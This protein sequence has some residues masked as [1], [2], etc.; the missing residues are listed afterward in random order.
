MTERPQNW[1]FLGDSLTEGVGSG[2][3]SY[4]TELAAQLRAADEELVV[5]DMRL[6]KVDPEGFNRFIRCNI[7]G[8]LSGDLRPARRRLW[9]WNLACEGRTIETDAEWLPLLDALRPCRVIVFRGSLESI[10]RPAMLGD[11]SWPWWVPQS[12]RSYAAMDPRCYFST[13][14]WRRVKQGAID[15]LKQTVRLSLLQRRTGVTL[16]DLDAL[17]AHYRTLLVH[18]RALDARV[19]MLGLLTTDGALFPGSPERFALVNVRLRE[20]AIA[21]GAEFFDWRT[22]F[23]QSPGRPG[24]LYRD[25]FHPN[26]DGARALATI[27]REHLSESSR[28]G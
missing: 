5:Q 7:A 17:I 25:G 14:W 21:Q 20:L 23:E 6:R 28:S 13:T 3:I 15:T 10:V 12:W 18:L 27:L 11:D 8:Y 19:L 16:M 4:V 22:R 1:V 9:L 2:R 26:Q 24:F